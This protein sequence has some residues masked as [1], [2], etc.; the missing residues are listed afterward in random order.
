MELLSLISNI[1]FFFLLLLA[2]TKI[3]KQ[4]LAISQVSKNLAFL[5]QL[6]RFMTTVSKAEV[7][8]RKERRVN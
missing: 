4:L 8:G 1:S 5:I 2:I 3:A 6:S 7:L